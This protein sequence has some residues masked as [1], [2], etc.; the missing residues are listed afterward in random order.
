M[1]T[2]LRWKVL[3]RLSREVGRPADLETV[4][5]V[6]Q[7]STG[8][9][10]QFSLPLNR[11]YIPLALIPT[12]TFYQALRSHLRGTGL[13][14]LASKSP[15]TTLPGLGDCA[16]SIQ[17]RLYT[18]NILVMTITVVSAV[19]GLLEESFQNLVSLRAMSEGLRKYARIV[20]GI[21]DSGEHKR[22]SEGM[23]L[24]VVPAYHLSYDA[25]QRGRRLDDLDVDY[26]R[27]V[28]ALL[29]GASEPDS[30]Q[31]TLVSDILYENRELNAKDSRQ[32]LLL[33]KQGLLLLADRK[34][35]AGDARVRFSRNFDLIELVRVFQLF[36]EEFPQ[37]RH[38]RENF[39]DYIYAQIRS[40]LMYPDAVL[41]QSYTNRLA[42]Q[43]LVDS[44]RLVD[45]FDMIQANNSRIV[46]QIDQKQPLFAQVSDRWWKS[47]D[48][49]SE[50]DIAALA[51]S[52]TLGRLTDSALRL[53]ILEDLRESETSLAGKNHKAAVVMAG[54]AVEAMLLALLEQETSLPVNRLR[55]MGLHELVEAVRKEGLVS[56][57][58]MLDL[59][60]NT[61]R[62]WRNFIHPGKAL[63]TGVSLTEDHATIVATGAI[64]LAKS[65]T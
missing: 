48:F 38:G 8:I 35:R 58:A 26:E 28:V 7:P 39:V 14:E 43:L 12:A 20:A 3:T 63:R 56:D 24:R 32:L 25:D 46:E 50:F 30:L 10:S 53:S 2:T 44:H 64:A 29:I 21:V 37:N 42:W 65:L 22:P 17:L 13:E 41:A 6:A 9:Y 16:V 33:N 51:M 40:F 49:G 19:T 60:D 62:Q 52:K 47:P 54:A 57:E 31:P 34:S 55:N 36:L 1:S 5:F 61:L 4:A 45:Q 27:R 23:N 11:S 59:L 18:P 15:R